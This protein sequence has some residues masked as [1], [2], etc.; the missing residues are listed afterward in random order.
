[1][2]ALPA[3]ETCFLLVWRRT[4]TGLGPGGGVPFLLGIVY[5]FHEGRPTVFVGDRRYHFWL[6]R[7]VSADFLYCF[8]WDRTV[9]WR[10]RAGS[11]EGWCWK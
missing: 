10:K 9:F 1:M 6:G 3:V 4:C 8:C 7:T 2:S 11:G 5:F